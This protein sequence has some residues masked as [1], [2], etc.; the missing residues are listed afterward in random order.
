MSIPIINLDI[1]ISTFTSFYLNWQHWRKINA[2]LSQV[3]FLSVGK[4]LNESYVLK[5]W[6]VEI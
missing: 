1:K 4:I 3:S 5:L 2:L 6:I